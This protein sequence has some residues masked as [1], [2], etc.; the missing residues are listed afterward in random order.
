MFKKIA[1]ALSFSP[2]SETLLKEAEK[3][4][5]IYSAELLIIRVS[6]KENHEIE[7]ERVAL[8]LE[9]LHIDDSNVRVIFEQGDPAKKIIKTCKKEQTD[10]LILGALKRESFFK[11]YLG[12]IARK[13]LRKSICSTLVLIAS[14]TA[15][16]FKRFSVDCG[17][18]NK[19]RKSLA[20]AFDLAHKA[21]AHVVHLVRDIKLYGLTM[22]LEEYSED[23]YTDVKKSYLERAAAE[24]E[25]TLKEIDTHHIKV[26]I[27][28]TGGR[29]ESE[30]V[31]FI[32]SSKT[33][34][35]VAPAPDNKIGILDRV[36]PHHLEYL[37]SDLPCNLL[38]VH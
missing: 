36:F 29:L 12:S 31:R 30:L 27:K 16:D 9:K 1:T 18:E 4:R 23:K 6:D 25:K 15:W 7:K 26:N 24:I 38:I 11:Q 5:K 13:V 32:K 10:L 22:A 19:T 21:D 8:L 3:F 35:L 20:T 17:G 33:D 34:L 28:I 14:E 37:F 2:Y